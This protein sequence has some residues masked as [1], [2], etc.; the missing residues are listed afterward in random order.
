MNAATIPQRGE[1]FSRVAENRRRRRIAVF[2]LRHRSCCFAGVLPERVLEWSENHR[3]IDYNEGRPHSSPMEPL[4]QWIILNLPLRK[5]SALILILAAQN[6]CGNVSAV[7]SSKP[8]RKRIAVIPG[9]G[10]GQ[11]VIPQAV[12]VTSI[13]P[14]STGAPI[15]IFAT[16]PPSLPMASPCCPAISTPSSPELSAIPA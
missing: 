14:S 6:P 12:N 3:N 9:D 7:D 2:G 15:A 10:I 11:E 1:L 13:S 8:S 5:N 16:E 4:R